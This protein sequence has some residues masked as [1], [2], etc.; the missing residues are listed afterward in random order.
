[1]REY[2]KGDVIL[3]EG[4]PNR[5]VFEITGGKVVLYEAFDTPQ[6]KKVDELGPGD[7]FGEQ[8]MLEGCLLTTTVV[9]GEEGA[10]VREISTD[11][12]YDFIQEEPGTVR[13]M[14]K[15]LST[16]LRR[17]TV[18]YEEASRRMAEKAGLSAENETSEAG[19]PIVTFR[20]GQIIFREGEVEECMY[21]LTD[22]RV[23]IF[24]GYG[25]DRQQLIVELE[26]ESF[27]GEMGVLEKLPRSATAVALEEGTKVEVIEEK[28][29]DEMIQKSPGMTFV[30]LQ[31]LSSRLRQMSEENRKAQKALEGMRS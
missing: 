19:C 27:F 29:L 6:E 24:T 22:G 2:K 11:T 3:R 18:E 21:F 20:Q 14:M 31:H 9:A 8:A 28:N 25:T 13:K 23:G 7:I 4:T 16:H 26:E 15:F 10:V 5:S 12:M 17:V 1:M 30:A